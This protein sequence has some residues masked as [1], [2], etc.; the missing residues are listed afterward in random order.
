[1][2]Y[3]GWGAGRV[4]RHVSNGKLYRGYDTRGKDATT[5]A[6]ATATTSTGQRDVERIHSTYTYIHQLRAVE[7]VYCK[8]VFL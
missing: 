3:R 5:A 2:L 4:G 8:G 7:R 1:M 6:T